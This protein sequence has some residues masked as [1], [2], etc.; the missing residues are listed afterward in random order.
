MNEAKQMTHPHPPSG[1]GGRSTTG[2]TSSLSKFT[3]SVDVKSALVNVWLFCP[4]ATGVT[5][6]EG[7]VPLENVGLDGSSRVESN[8]PTLMDFWLSSS[9][10]LL[11]FFLNIF[12]AVS[13]N[14]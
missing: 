8:N 13:K 6:N 10:I 9:A 14:A 11:G 5:V 12:Q 3:R 2:I 4:P 7:G 1:G